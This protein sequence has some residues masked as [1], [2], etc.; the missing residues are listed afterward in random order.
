ME[1][2]YKVSV[3]KSMPEDPDIIGTQTITIRERVLRF[4]FG[5]K[6]RFM[7][8]VPGGSVESLDITEVDHTRAEEVK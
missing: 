3:K 4:L 7:V 2:K 1:Q 5:N 8:L 6:H